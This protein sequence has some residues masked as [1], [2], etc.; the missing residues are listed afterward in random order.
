[1]DLHGLTPEIERPGTRTSPRIN[2]SMR[3]GRQAL[4]MGILPMKFS[5]TGWKPVPLTSEFSDTGGMPVPLTLEFSD[6]GGMPVPLTLE[7]SDTRG[8]PVPHR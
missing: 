1:M 8:M 5:D 6:T 3:R 7:F 4:G 2:L